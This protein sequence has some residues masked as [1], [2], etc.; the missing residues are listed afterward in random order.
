MPPLRN[1]SL[2]SIGYLGLIMSYTEDDGE[3]EL[4]T[5][6]ISEDRFL[7]D[8]EIYR[9]FR[10]WVILLQKTSKRSYLNNLVQKSSRI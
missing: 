3:E 1:H 4:S 7:I 2:E 6:V 9:S 5:S 8:F 10:S